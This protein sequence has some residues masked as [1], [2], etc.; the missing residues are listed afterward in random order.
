MS[1]REAIYDDLAYEVFAPV[2]LE[3]FN[4]LKANQ[5]IHPSKYFQLQKKI[6]RNGVPRDFANK[7][8][9]DQINDMKLQ[10]T[11]QEAAG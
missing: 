11:E 6:E 8:V 1:T 3:L 5:E 4:R 7:Y 2:E 10:I 9:K